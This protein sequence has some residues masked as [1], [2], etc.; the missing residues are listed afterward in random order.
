MVASA[1][2]VPDIARAEA[3]LME[4]EERVAGIFDRLIGRP[5]P[6]RDG[7]QGAAPS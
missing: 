6:L 7:K 3:L 2:Q 1:A 5:E 4:N